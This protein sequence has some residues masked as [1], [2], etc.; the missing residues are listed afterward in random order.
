MP[1][2]LLRCRDRSTRRPALALAL[3]AGVATAVVAVAPGA[4]AAGTPDPLEGAVRNVLPPGQSG[5]IDAAK[6][7]TVV[8]GDS[9]G[10]VA[11]EGRNAPPNFADQ[12]EMY[13]GLNRLDPASVSAGDVSRLYKRAGFTPDTVV[14]SATPRPGV[15]IRWDAYGVPYVDGQSAED[16][17]FGAGYA[18]TMDRMFLQDVLRHAGAARAAEFLGPTEGN[19]AMD[20]HQLQTAAYTPA[21]AQAQLDGVVQRYDEEGRT[22]LARADAYLAGINAA[23]HAL[24]PANLPTGLHCPAEYAAL[25]KTP[26][27]WTRADLVYVA[28][29]VGGIFGKGGGGEADNARWLQQL[30]GRFGAAQGLAYYRDLRAK[31][32]PE[33]PTTASVRTPYGGGDPNPAQPGV[34]LPDMAGPTAD[35][36]GSDVGGTGL[37]LPS[38]PPSLGLDMP[39][40]T[41]LPLSTRG[42]S[43]AA[44]I[45]GSR[46]ADGHP[47]VVFGPQTGYYAPQLLSEEVLNG[48]G[49]HA[50][51]VS[52]AGTSLVVELGRGLDYAWSATSA[53]SDIVDTV[54]ERLCEPDGSTPTVHST[55]YL[56]DGRCV[57]MTSWVHE[58]TA[59]P[60]AGATN[61]PQQLRMQVL[62]TGH[63]IVQSRVTVHGIP[64]ALVLQ[65]STYG[66]EVDSVIGFARVNDPAQVHDPASFNRAMSAIDYTF[67]WFFANDKDIAYFGSGRLPQRA[68]GTDLDFPRW[69]VSRYD[70]T[71]WVPTSGH[72]QQ[73]DPPSGYLVSWNNKQ[74]PGFSAADN[75]WGYNSIYRSRAL[76]DRVGALAATGHATVPQLVG[77]VADAA[78]VDSRARYTLPALLDVL[79]DGGSDPQT[80]KAVALLRG[81]LAD[82][83]HR[84]DRARTGHYADQA[85]IALFDEWWQPKHEAVPDSSSGALPKDVLRPVLGSLVDQLPKA[86]DD[87]P[88]GGKGSSWNE[89]A[90]YG[91]VDAELRRA[92]GHGPSGTRTASLCGLRTSCA[93]TVIASLTAAVQRAL[94]AQ[95]V[96]DVD[97]LTYDKHLDDIR[98]TTAGLVGVRPIDWQNRPTFQQVVHFTTER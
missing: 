93:D 80:R 96:T 10:R 34:A 21:E 85:A 15:R 58:E 47:T 22:L 89:V 20:R 64:V 78:T 74:A 63:G 68:A 3:L 39:H 46:S 9:Q 36:T 55:H 31:N 67:N 95:K 41:F 71:G 57:P 54:A 73:A 17:A 65:R 94:A 76:S 53:S 12:L 23:Q 81:W 92:L 91:Y 88:R 70:W 28:S 16:V 60:N 25:Q 40:G 18:G 51:G 27:D 2:V 4:T 72:V 38:A 50:R 49:I 5:S 6:L 90:W 56:A 69:G 37:P 33:A 87:H 43:N 35:G 29:L 11:V 45:A 8:A 24:C 75:V 62:R 42:A 26:K 59:L 84:V 97:A 48:P 83:A 13:D 30:Q 52:F 1:S 79:G 32:D 98:H 61:P 86:L 82:G 14:R 77:A 19:I 44:L 7:A 66:H